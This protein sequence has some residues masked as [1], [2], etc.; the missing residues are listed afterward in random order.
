MCLPPDGSSAVEN[1]RRKTLAASV[2]QLVMPVHRP[3]PH[4]NV[5]PLEPMD[6][7]TKI[8]SQAL[9]VPVSL[10]HIFVSPLDVETLRARARG[11]VKNAI[12]YNRHTGAPEPDGLFD[13]AI[14]GG[15]ASLVPSPS[16]EDDVVIRER[17][18]R[19]GRLVLSE[20]V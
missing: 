18:T 15:G 1:R 19:F 4:V 13:E 8:L 5:L 16:G 9:G 14:F 6:S 12:T 17:A 20:P 7:E 3:P 11:V 10:R 2:A